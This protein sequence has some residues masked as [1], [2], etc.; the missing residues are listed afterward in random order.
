MKPTQPA[1]RSVNVEVF[2]SDWNPL[3]I[4]HNAFEFLLTDLDTG[5][6]F[7]DVADSTR[8]MAV[9]RRNH[10]NARRAYD[11][12]VRFM[13]NLSLD[14]TQRKAL[15]ERLALLKSRLENVGESF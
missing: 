4:S 8:N 1:R 2:M 11:S 15:A 6:T 10:A 9:R 12:V 7:M 14:D 5:L 3:S 13:R